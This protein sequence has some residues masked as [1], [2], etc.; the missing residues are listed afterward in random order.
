MQTVV[1][2]VIEPK[3]LGWPNIKKTNRPAKTGDGA[4]KCSK[5]YNTEDSPVV[6]PLKNRT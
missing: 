5:T 6:T 2:K 1:K 3:A 4:K